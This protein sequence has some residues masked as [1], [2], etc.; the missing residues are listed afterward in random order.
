MAKK[1]RKDMKAPS[2]EKSNFLGASGRNMTYKDLKRKAI[3]LGMPFPDACSAGVFDLLHYINVSEEKPDKSLIDKY[4]DWMDKQLENIGYSKDD[5]LR[6]SRLRL[7][8]LGEEGGKWAKKNQTSSRNKETSRKETT[9]REG[10]NLIL[11]RVQRNLMYS[12]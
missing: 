11:S 3:I 10:M 12:N 5:P 7:G 8:F 6:N 2:K 4:D 9:K 1:S